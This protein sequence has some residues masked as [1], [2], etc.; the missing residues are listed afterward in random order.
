MELR[1]QLKQ[2]EE[3]LWAS[4]VQV[5]DLQRQVT[6]WRTEEQAEKDAL[7]RQDVQLRN[8]QNEHFRLENEIASQK[9]A[10]EALEEHLRRTE[11]DTEV[12]WNQTQQL[13]EQEQQRLLQEGTRW[14]D[15]SQDVSKKAV[16]LEGRFEVMRRDCL[17]VREELRSS[18]SRCQDVSSMLQTVERERDEW[19]RKHRS[20]HEGL[21]RFQLEVHQEKVARTQIEHSSDEKLGSAARQLQDLDT[22]LKDS[23][24]RYDKLEQ[25]TAVD[26]IKFRT[27]IEEFQ[28]ALAK[29]DAAKNE[30]E[31]IIAELKSVQATTDHERQSL[32]SKV[33]VLEDKIQQ[34]GLTKV[35]IQGS[36]ESMKRD[37]DQVQTMVES[38]R[39]QM[40][41]L[42]HK[43]SQYE[44]E[45]DGALHMEAEE[46]K[47]SEDYQKRMREWQREEERR[48]HQERMRA[49]SM[50]Q[51][52]QA[53]MTRS[54][55]TKVE[56]EKTLQA[57]QDDT[58]QLAMALQVQHEKAVNLD[59]CM[60]KNLHVL[61]HRIQDLQEETR[62]GIVNASSLM[63]SG[64]GFTAI[65]PRTP[66]PVKTSGTMALESSSPSRL[67][68]R[69]YDID[70]KSPAFS[71]PLYRVASLSSHLGV[72][73]LGNP[74]PPNP[75][76]GLTGSL[77]SPRA[78]SPGISAPFIGAL[79]PSKEPLPLGPGPSIPVGTELSPKTSGL[80]TSP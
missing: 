49:E 21:E 29:A 77:L 55:Q 65:R 1:M 63:T 75:M 37:R 45:R 31:Q 67:A 73:A 61:D 74:M 3:N 59:G 39:T 72:P 14:R 4:N 56:L 13:H 26:T 54:E 69:R 40:Q 51:Q 68:L 11:R 79:S 19:V 33:R 17:S 2:T 7:I 70:S 24:W 46:K 53:E 34:D 20:C 43:S 10:R 44:R 38:Y 30:Q 5:D 41:T 23:R 35:Q 66:S 32:A 15:I 78:L 12:S 18:E 80:R 52:A 47:K 60:R 62:S 48:M 71:D 27:E 28:R 64:L 25:S 9:Q 57:L 42:E 76:P 6:Q 50:C 58:R 36:L 22:S 8:A 16:D